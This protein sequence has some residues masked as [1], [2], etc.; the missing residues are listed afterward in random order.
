MGRG[1]D[2][3]HSF[4]VYNSYRLSGLLYFIYYIASTYAR[5]MSIYHRITDESGKHV[6]Q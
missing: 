4:L 1:G 3:G 2:D 5:P 6:S